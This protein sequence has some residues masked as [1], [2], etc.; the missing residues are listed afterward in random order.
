[1]LA[2]DAEAALKAHSAQYDGATPGKY[3]GVVRATDSQGRAVGSEYRY[4][5]TGGGSAARPV[6]GV[7]QDGV[8]IVLSPP[9]QVQR[10]IAV[11][12]S[13]YFGLN[14][15]VATEALRDQLTARHGKPGL[16]L[17]DVVAA[18]FLDKAHR[19]LPQ[20]VLTGPGHPTVVQNCGNPAF[21][22]PSNLI[23][24]TTRF[25]QVEYQ[26]DPR[27]LGLH[28]E[29]GT[30]LWLAMGKSKAGTVL[31]F[32]TQLVDFPAFIDATLAAHAFLKPQADAAKDKE[33][34]AARKRGAPRL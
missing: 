31:H 11:R 16:V 27:T 33:K 18:W 19:S 30:A 14:D 32:T 22:S 15:T 6:N 17:D 34:D 23:Q 4:H 26:K 2:S 21:F 24:N 8:E 20:P 7:R 25:W 1:M 28:R 13:V 3:I 12:R 9:P 5:L 10:V 29:C